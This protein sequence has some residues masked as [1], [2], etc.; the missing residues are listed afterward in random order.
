[1]LLYRGPGWKSGGIESNRIIGEN[2]AFKALELYKGAST[3][4]SGPVDYVQRY[5]DI[6][7]AV[8]MNEHGEKI[9]LCAPAMVKKKN[10]I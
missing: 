6:T 1:M 9:K 2:Q 3:Q 8:V 10:D 5:W 7:K 4:V